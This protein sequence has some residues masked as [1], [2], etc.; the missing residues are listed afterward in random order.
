MTAWNGLG[1]L[2][3]GVGGGRGGH[4]SFGVAGHVGATMDGGGGEGGRKSNGRGIAPPT[5][6]LSIATSY[7]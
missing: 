7:N 2:C 5:P 1:N 4:L 3:S 6:K